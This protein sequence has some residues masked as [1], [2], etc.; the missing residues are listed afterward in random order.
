M[1]EIYRTTSQNGRWGL[2]LVSEGI[3]E[4]TR[5]T[6]VQA[7]LTT[8]GETEGHRVVRIEPTDDPQWA[9][10]YSC[11]AEPLSGASRVETIDLQGNSY[12]TLLL[13]GPRALVRTWGYK[14]RS[15]RVLYYEDGQ[16]QDV[17]A[18]V[19]L[20]LGMLDSKVIPSTVPPPPAF[21][22]GELA[23]EAQR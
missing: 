9:V 17:P 18:S 20:A 21:D 1:K 12:V 19:L 22:V 14:G 3:P 4:L 16:Q 6:P 8:L 2:A 11:D 13:L 15:S 10:I 7:A 23:R 5:S